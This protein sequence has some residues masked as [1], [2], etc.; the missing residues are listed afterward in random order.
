MLL[1]ISSPS[2]CVAI[3]VR[4]CVHLTEFVGEGETLHHA[5]VHQCLFCRT[6]RDQ[7]VALGL[8]LILSHAKK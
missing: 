8:E 2:P 3:R 4:V 5:L 6:V 1:S 7:L